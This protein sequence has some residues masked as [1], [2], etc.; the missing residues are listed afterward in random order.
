M[1]HSIPSH[2][3]L[4]HLFLF[5]V[6]CHLVLSCPIFHCSVLPCPISL[7]LS[8]PLISSCPAV[9]C[10][11]LNLSLVILFSQSCYILF[12]PRQGT[13]FKVY[14]TKLSHNSPYSTFTSLV[15]PVHHLLCCTVLSRPAKFA[16]FSHASGSL[17]HLILH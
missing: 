15:C 6:L 2:Y 4:S 7:V 16:P 14:S 3:V 8:S 10:H 13:K 5:L 17:A 12:S 1:S 9:T 11:I